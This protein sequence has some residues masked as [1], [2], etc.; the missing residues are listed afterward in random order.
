[1]DGAYFPFRIRHVEP[2]Y[3]FTVRITQ[4]KNNP[5]VADSVFLKTDSAAGEQ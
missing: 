4:V 5:P 2:G 3:V 1:V